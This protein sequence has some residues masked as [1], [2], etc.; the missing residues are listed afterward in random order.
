MSVMDSEQLRDHL[1]E[2]IDGMD[3][4]PNIIK[5]AKLN[6]VDAEISNVELE[7]VGMRRALVQYDDLAMK[8][9]ES[10]TLGVAIG[11]AIEQLKRLRAYREEILALPEDAGRIER[12]GGDE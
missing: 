5:L 6:D 10:T 9:D 11:N 12:G 3:V 7:L 1:L 4:L 2:Q 8:V